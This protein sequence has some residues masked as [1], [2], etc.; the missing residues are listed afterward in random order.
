MSSGLGLFFVHNGENPLPQIKRLSYITKFIILLISSLVENW[1][2]I[3][4]LRFKVLTFFCIDCFIIICFLIGSRAQ[5]F[6]WFVCLF[7]CFFVFLFF[8]LL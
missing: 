8:C 4:T 7:V 3:N 5:S 6:I 2:S 1:C